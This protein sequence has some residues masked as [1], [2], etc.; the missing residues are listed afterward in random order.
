M[1]LERLNVYTGCRLINSCLHAFANQLL[2]QMLG[3]CRCQHCNANISLTIRNA[4]SC[5]FPGMNFL[6]PPEFG[7]ICL[8]WSSLKGSKQ[9]FD[10]VV[11]T[12]L[13]RGLNRPTLLDQRILLGAK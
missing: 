6:G 3:V 4:I 2:A 10:T 8:N 13:S 9:A 1:Q 5:W 7:I 11:R 12:S